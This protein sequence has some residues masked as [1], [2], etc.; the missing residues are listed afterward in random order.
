MND[1]CNLKKK[2]QSSG[3][4]FL[5]NDRVCIVVDPYKERKRYTVTESLDIIVS[6]N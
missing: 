5:R 6:V 1:N 3:A 2:V 4:I